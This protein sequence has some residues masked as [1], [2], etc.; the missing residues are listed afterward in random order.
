MALTTIN[1]SQETRNKLKDCGKKGQTYDEVIN[2][3]LQLRTKSGR[4][5]N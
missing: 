1:V 4:S 3:L 2:E 5:A